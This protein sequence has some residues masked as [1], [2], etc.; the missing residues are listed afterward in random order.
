MIEP[1]G[2][3]QGEDAAEAIRLGLALPLPHGLA[4]TMARRDGQVLPVAALT[5][6]L[7]TPAP[8]AGLP[9]RPLVMG[10]VNVTPDSF[11]N[12][13]EQFAFRDAVA[14]ALAMVAPWTPARRSST[15]YPA[16]GTTLTRQRWWHGRGAPWC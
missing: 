1:I 3:L 7:P 10:I 12:G 13:G 16:S 15:T 4:F 9:P 8:W 11:S 14:S 6:V 2:L 5:E